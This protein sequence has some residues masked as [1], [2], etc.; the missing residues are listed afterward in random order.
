M[1]YFG[2][3]LSFAG[4]DVAHQHNPF[5][6]HQAV[7]QMTAGRMSAAMKCQRGWNL[8]YRCFTSTNHGKGSCF[9]GVT[10]LETG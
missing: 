10:K 4:I 7:Q 1:A 2:L 3:S 9:G 5:T 6:A 8:D